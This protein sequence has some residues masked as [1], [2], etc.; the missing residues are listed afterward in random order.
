MSR[1]AT[2]ADVAQRAGVS[3]ATVSYVL[4]D[5]PGHSISEATREKVLAAADELGYIPPTT[6]LALCGGGRSRR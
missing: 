2:S 5:R 3:R 1:R 6:A 4:N